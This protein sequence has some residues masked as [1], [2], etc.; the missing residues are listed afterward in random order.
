[1]GK[2]VSLYWH[3]LEGEVLKFDRNK[4]YTLSEIDKILKENGTKKING[5]FIYCGNKP[6]G[7]TFTRMVIRST[8]K[9][10]F[11]LER[12]LFDK[13][14]DFKSLNSFNKETKNLINFESDFE[15]DSIK[16]LNASTAILKKINLFNNDSEE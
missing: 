3:E 4:A 13:K 14:E 5:L 6:L 11:M 2:Q 7:D 12:K 1:M 16:T 9:E 10:E 8:A 15:E